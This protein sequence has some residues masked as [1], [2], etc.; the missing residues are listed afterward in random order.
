[1]K[2]SNTGKI[3]VIGAIIFVFIVGIIALII[4]V[5][6][7]TPT[8]ITISNKPTPPITSSGG[9]HSPI[10]KSWTCDPSKGGPSGVLWGGSNPKIMTQYGTDYGNAWDAS[11]GTCWAVKHVPDH[12]GL[13]VNNC[14][15]G[16]YPDDRHQVCQYC[17]WPVLEIKKIK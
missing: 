4:W 1:M 13:C 10:S 15:P 2:N 7:S 8:S 5:F 14:S 12:G 11:T 9:N 6:A 3:I 16:L 17:S